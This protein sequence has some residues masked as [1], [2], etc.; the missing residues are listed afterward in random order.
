MVL[1]GAL[2]FQDPSEILK[3]FERGVY[4]VHTEDHDGVGFSIGGGKYL[5]TCDHVIGSDAKITVLE[6][7]AATRHGYLV[8]HDAKLDIAVYRLDRVSPISL[9][10]SGDD[11]K[12]GKPVY[13]VSD[14][15]GASSRTF[16]S[17]TILGVNRDGD[18]AYYQFDLKLDKKD[19]GS[20]LLNAKGEVIGMAQASTSG[21]TTLS[22]GISG[23]NLNKYLREQAVPPDEPTV[24]GNLGQVLDTTRVC[25]TPDLDSRSLFIAAPLQY[26]IVSDYSAD[27]LK[28][29][30]T[31][32]AVGYI[33]ST[34]VKIVVPNITKGTAGIVNGYEVVRVVKSFDASNLKASSTTADWQK[35]TARFVGSI[36]AT[37]GREIS[38][39]ASIQIDIGR[40]VTSVDDLQIGDRIYF[41]SRNALFA[42]IYMGNDEYISVDKAGKLVTTKFGSTSAKPFYRALH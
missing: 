30:L 28:V 25:E 18:R 41:G 9:S 26:L 24:V 36:F 5:M 35:E 4:A 22:A 3:K 17:G 29:T 40:P 34:M 10:I 16:A 14:E 21:G 13:V 6:P 27:F 20:P 38:D 23:Y 2:M 33:R 1:I 32:G 7:K 37:S 12:A 39:D 15:S 31:N 8:F 42:A 11:Q 19:S